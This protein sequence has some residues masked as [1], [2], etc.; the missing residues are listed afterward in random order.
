MNLPRKGVLDRL[1]KDI[2]SLQGYHQLPT[3]NNIPIGFRPIEN[4]FP[5]ARF[6]VGCMH[7]FINLSVEGASATAG[8]I[9]ALLHSRMQLGGACLWISASRTLFPA[10]LSL[11]GIAPHQVIFVDVRSEKEVLYAT[12]EALKCNR[13]TAVMSEIKELNF[14][15]SRR[16]QLAAEKS[17]VT[18][19]VLR[20]QPRALST[21]ACVSRWQVTP[22]PSELSDGMPGVGFPRWSVELQK[23][24]NGKPGKWIIEWTAGGFREVKDNSTMQAQ[25]Q[26]RKLG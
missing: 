15:V 23:V 26:Q 1:Q 4:R 6:P 19:F 20:T 9:A 16:F 25:E 3:E 24:R 13:L 10:A 7:E 22:L 5:L 8:F 11:Y 17:R 12:E 18:G 21:T 2:L 14:R